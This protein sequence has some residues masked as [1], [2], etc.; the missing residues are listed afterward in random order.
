ME[1]T[2]RVR[3]LNTGSS[4]FYDRWIHFY[5]EFPCRWLKKK[6]NTSYFVTTPFWGLLAHHTPCSAAEN[7]WVVEQHYFCWHIIVLNRTQHR[8]DDTEARNVFWFL[9][10]DGFLICGYLC[11]LC[12]L[13]WPVKGL[14]GCRAA[15]K[16]KVGVGP[17]TTCCETPSMPHVSDPSRFGLWLFSLYRDLL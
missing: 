12:L 9:E 8:K 3:G 14:L 7:Q 15:G 1:L 2:A 10:R 13:V 11:L 4:T 16:R 6:N 17:K 5:S